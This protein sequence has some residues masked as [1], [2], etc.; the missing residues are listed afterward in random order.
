MALKSTC[1]LMRPDQCCLKLSIVKIN[2]FIEIVHF[3]L[4]FMRNSNFERTT[5]L[6]RNDFLYNNLSSF[7][8]EQSRIMENYSA[9]LSCH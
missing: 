4:F 3:G 1:S 9:V 5:N 8:I 6:N 7:S 2:W